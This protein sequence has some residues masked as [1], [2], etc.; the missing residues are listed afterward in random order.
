MTTDAGQMHRALMALVL[1]F[2]PAMGSA[3]GAARR[4]PSSAHSNPD[5]FLGYSYTKAGE[6][7]LH[8]WQLSGSYPLGSSLLGGSL[9]LVGDVS[10]HYGSFAGADLSQL[11]FLAGARCAWAKRRLSPFAEVLAGGVRTKT[12]V[13]LVDVSLSDSD[14][15]WGG[16][17]GGG[18]DYRLSGPWAVRAAI[19]LLVLRA[20]G[21]WDSDPRLSLGVVYR[22]R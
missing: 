18:V 13:A 22:F 10:G 20:E 2:L 5:A 4:P 1:L 6:A 3:G 15:D 21:A 17:V 9:R 12:S 11:T 14:T 19:D 7:S 16:A 8:G